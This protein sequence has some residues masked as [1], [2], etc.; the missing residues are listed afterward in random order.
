MWRPV[1][2]IEEA[3]IKTALMATPH[4]SLVARESQGKWSYATVWRV[5]DRAG[6]ELTAGRETMGRHR[7]SA[8]Q[9]AVVIEARHA[10]PDASQKDIAQQAGVSRSSVWRVE[11]GSPHRRADHRTRPPIACPG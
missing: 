11:G 7:L 10:N 6:I 1:S 4:A 9:K 8:E 5:A 3:K 2:D